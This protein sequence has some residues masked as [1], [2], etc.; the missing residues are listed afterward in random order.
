M[1]TR[2]RIGLVVALL[3]AAAF[4]ARGAAAK[5]AGPHDYPTAARADF[6]IGC[7]A[8]NG[9]SRLYLD[10]C[11]CEIDTIARHMTYHDYELASTIVSMQ[12]GGLGIRGAMFKVTP[13]AK[14]E[15]RRLHR[16]EAEANLHCFGG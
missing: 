14:T 4:G 8:A 12:Q 10:R 1:R 16:A 15:M 9:F 13:V 7:L 11:A 5:P 3:A 2:S 6:V